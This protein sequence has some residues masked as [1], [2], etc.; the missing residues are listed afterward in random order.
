MAIDEAMLLAGRDVALRLYSWRPPAVS[1][2]Y[3]QAVADFED[4]ASQFTLVRRPTGG[5]AI[6]HHHEITFALAAPLDM[7]PA[8]VL[9]SYRL[10]HEACVAALRA[11]GVPARLAVAGAGSGRRS[12]WCFAAAGPGDV[13]LEDGRKL[14]GSAQRRIAR[15]VPRVLHHGSVVLRAPAATPFCG[16][17]AAHLDP[18]RADP[19]LRREIARELGRRL[20]VEFVPSLISE[21]E[22]RCARRL[23]EER[24]ANPTFVRRR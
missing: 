16:E 23:R 14:V 17:V 20:E 1:L 5:G 3:F 11:A 8:P 18:R 12:R 6:C 21:A 22:R 15:P 13:V 9:E 24:Y 4:V 19:V 2:G 7:L 10:V